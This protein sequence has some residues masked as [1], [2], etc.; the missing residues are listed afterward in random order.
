MGKSFHCFLLY[1]ALIY[2]R[3]SDIH[4][5]EIIERN[6]FIFNR[7]KEFFA[8]VVV[9]LRTNIVIDL[10]TFFDKSSSN[11]SYKDLL[12]ILKK[13]VP[14]NTYSQV[15]YEVEQRV[16]PLR[17]IVQSL[18]D[19]RH[20]HIAH[21]GKQKKDFSLT[22]EQLELVFTEAQIIFNLIS[23]HC[24]DSHT[25]FDLCNQEDVDSDIEA[26]F[27]ELYLGF[28]EYKKVVYRNVYQGGSSV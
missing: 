6:Q 15:E 16:Q 27:N 14:N 10:Y 12:G 13:S 21:E 11:Y 8:P 5:E 28:E 23:H 9:A 22:I 17:S 26:L 4:S 25:S 19:Y 3:A 1:K 18:K 7:H 20:S 2:H 24:Q